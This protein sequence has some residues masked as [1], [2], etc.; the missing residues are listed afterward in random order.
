MGTNKKKSTTKKVDLEKSYYETAK[1][2]NKGK[3]SAPKKQ[4]NKGGLIALLL[5]SGV[6]LLCLVFGFLYLSGFVGNAKLSDNITI[7]GVNVSGMNRQDAISAINKAVSSYR[8]TPMEV[9]VG[10]NTVVLA[11]ETANVSLDV[12][13]AVTVAF[14]K[15][16]DRGAFDVSSYLT[17]NEDAVRKALAPLED[18]YKESTFVE[19]SYTIIG[20]RPAL[21]EAHIDDPVQQVEIHTGS[22]SYVFNADD[23]YTVVLKAYGENSATAKYD[24]P[25]KA[26]TPI[27]LAAIHNSL[28]VAPVNATMDKETF[29]ISEHAYGYGLDIPAAEKALSETPYGQTLTISFVR[30]APKDTQE[31]LAGL[32]FQ[33]V[34]S[35]YKAVSSSQPYTRDVNLRLSCE[36]INGIV[37][38]PG[39]VFSYNATLGE[40][41]PEKGYKQAAGYWGTE[42]IQSYGGGICQASSSL[43]YCAMMADLEIVERHNHGYLSSYMPYGMDAT[44]DWS[45]PDFKFKNTTEYP[46]RIEA[47]A[48]GGT[49]VVTL[50]GTDTKDYYVKM[51]YEILKVENYNVVYQEVPRDNNPKGYWDGYVI[52]DPYTGYTIRTYRCRYD[53]ETDDLLSRDFEVQSGYTK[54]DKLVVKLVDPTPAPEPEPTPTPTPT[55]TPEPTPDPEP[56]PEPEPTPDPNPEGGGITPD[57]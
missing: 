8:T 54:R 1:K 11:P 10:D 38:L 12:N 55:P 50:H 31:S 53:K 39:E 6:L 26:P 45:G 30:I 5:G 33:D 36:A 44:V 15:R 20:Q 17:I 40:R 52:N 49:V 16:Y 56:A 24:V 29:E 32:L 18:P 43:Y 23:L 27:D 42:I 48:T 46:I 7:A 41:T 21:D 35:T 22:P 47:Y 3:Y 34:L 13:K 25:T 2:M 51:D 37:L 28:Y 19:S 9:T 57:E 4:K 14:L